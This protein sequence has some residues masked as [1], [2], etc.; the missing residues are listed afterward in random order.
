MR[1][2]IFRVA[3]VSTRASEMK[4]M[5][6][7]HMIYLTAIGLP[8]CGSSILHIYTETTHRTTQSTQTIH[9][10]TQLTNWEEYWPCPVSARYTLAFAL[11]LREEHG[12]ISV[13]AVGEWQFLQKC[14]RWKPCGRGRLDLQ[15]A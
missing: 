4:L 7:Y 6:R 3:E 13:R 8:P 1:R 2:F 14:L 12:K 15:S 5:I 10:T 11:Q 9:R